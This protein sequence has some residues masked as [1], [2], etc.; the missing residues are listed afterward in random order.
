MSCRQG[1][2]SAGD[3]A[4]LGD[5]G[6]E[7]ETASGQSS[8]INRGGRPP[9]YFRK[10]HFNVTEEAGRNNRKPLRC[11]HCDQLVESRVELLQKHC[12]KECRQIP[13][14]LKKACED[15]IVATTVPAKRPCSTLSRS[16]LKQQAPDVGVFMHR[17]PPQQQDVL[18]RKLFLMFCMNAIPFRVADSPYFL[19]FIQYA[20][21]AFKPAG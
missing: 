21:K 11:L 9:N 7:G 17:V 12:L 14:E 8:N 6:S 1:L 20:N 13:P 2:L 16:S 5:Q 10:N 4:V 18:N 19:D 3:Q 15:H